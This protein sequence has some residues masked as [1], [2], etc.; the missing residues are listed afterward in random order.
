MPNADIG[1]EKTVNL[2][3][4]VMYRLSDRLDWE[5]VFWTTEMFDALIVAP[6]RLGG[7][8]SVLYDGQLSRVLANQNQRRARL[9]GFSTEL[10][11]DFND[12]FA[13]Y[14]NVGYTRGRILANDETGTAEAPLDHIPPLYGRAG[15]RFHVPRA[16]AEAFVLFNGEKPLD[17]YYLNGEDNE[18]YAPPGGM[19]AWWTLN[20][21][22]YY[23]FLNDALTLQ[24]GIDNMFD[25]QYRIFASGIN[26][27]GQ[28]VFVAL[29]AKW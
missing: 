19:P 8:D 22:L 7:Q 10:E 23:R 26:A 14:G 27:P 11:A 2:D 28:N 17:Q 9:W 24:A 6:F 25:A 16:G 4:N 12:R 18:Q 1:P 29:R 5:T 21:R 13:A 20:L 3:L 15:L